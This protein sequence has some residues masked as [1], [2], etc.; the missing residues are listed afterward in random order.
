M[1]ELKKEK[2]GRKKKKIETNLEAA[3]AESETHRTQK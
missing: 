3:M 2:N 1:K